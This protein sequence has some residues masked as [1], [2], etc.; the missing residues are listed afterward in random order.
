MGEI[1][2]FVLL[3]YGVVK[4]LRSVKE[5][6]PKWSSAAKIHWSLRKAQ[7]IL[8]MPFV[9]VVGFFIIFA[10][11]INPG[12]DLIP[13]SI[14]A[15]GTFGDSFGVLN[16]LFSGLGFAGLTL[17]LWMQ[18][19]QIT[20]QATESKKLDEARQVDRYEATLH[21]LLDLYRKCLD[22]VTSKHVI[23]KIHSRTALAWTTEN[24]LR[25]LRE[26]AVD[27]EVPVEVVERYS[28]GT[29]TETDGLLLDEAFFNI[30]SITVYTLEPHRCLTDTFTLL[31]RH[32]VD[33][34]PTFLGLE[35][36]MLLV[37]SQITSSEMAYFFYLA[38]AFKEEGE[39]RRLLASSHLLAVMA[40]VAQIPQVHQLLYGRLWGESA[41]ATYQ[42]HVPH[43]PF[44]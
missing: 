17:T 1:I 5:D 20:S 10:A 6:I 34:P 25:S 27:V 12:D 29:L 19:R 44:V 24:V 7:Y 32:L 4:S 31:L 15:R 35:P 39:L 41:N 9:G 30:A 23:E 43:R 18:Q 21:R 42:D 8:A 33:D 40:K 2:L 22:E 37:K 3:I 26:R 38:L 16:S 11:N 28:A 36:Y 14:A 13:D